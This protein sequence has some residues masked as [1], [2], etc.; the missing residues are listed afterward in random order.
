MQLRSLPI[1]LVIAAALAGCSASSASDPTSSS[2]AAETTVP[3]QAA[4]RC[5]GATLDVN[6]DERRDI[7]FVIRDAEA[8]EHLPHGFDLGGEHPVLN[9]DGDFILTG[10]V[11]Q[12]IFHASDFSRVV[13]KN[14]ADVTGGVAKS[15][16]SWFPS[17]GDP[18]DLEIWF[19]EYTNWRFR[20]CAYLF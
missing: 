16:A 10:H 4:I 5:D 14:G 8:I 7:Q 3:W 19:G 18:N 9:A 12:G 6:A 15:S 17:G 11:D 2:Q 1:T 13:V 20:N